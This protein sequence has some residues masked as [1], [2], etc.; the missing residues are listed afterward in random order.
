MGID[1]TVLAAAI[2]SVVAL[3][4]YLGSQRIQHV[5]RRAQIFAQAMRAVD[6]V[7]ELPYLIWRRSDS[8]PETVRRLGERQSILLED[9]RYYVNLLRIENPRVAKVY[10]LLAVRVRRQTHVNRRIAWED[11]LIGSSCHLADSPP[12]E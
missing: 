7:H 1:P 9:V 12:F 6:Q 11:P 10:Y 5:E 3:I 8:S 2:A 4:G